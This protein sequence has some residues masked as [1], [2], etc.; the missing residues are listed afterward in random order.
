MEG[1]CWSF[2]GES[3]RQWNWT[4]LHQEAKVLG[5]M[6]L[7]PAERDT[8]FR[9]ANGGCSRI[10]ARQVQLQ[11]GDTVIPL[12]VRKYLPVSNKLSTTISNGVDTHPGKSTIIPSGHRWTS[13][14]KNMLRLINQYFH[15]RYHE[16][17]YQKVH[18]T[19]CNG[20]WSAQ[21]PISLS[22]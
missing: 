13:R 2:N 18:G 5:Q 11:P 9:R 10:K 16:Y 1:N 3:H 12:L 17:Q 14:T 20:Y 15:T 22:W 6:R 19:T 7:S 21:D 8:I 4:W